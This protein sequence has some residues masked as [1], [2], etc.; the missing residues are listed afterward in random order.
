MSET[1]SNSSYVPPTAAA[2][3]LVEMRGIG[4]AFAGVRVL[5][6]VRFELR[7]GEVHVLAGENGA[8]KSTLMKIL[9]GVYA[10]YEGEIRL[11]GR[12]VRFKSPHH[13]FR[14]GIAVIHQEMSLIPDL[15]VVDNIFLGR[16][17]VRR[18]GWLDRTG[19]RAK[20]R[21]ILDQL[22]LDLDERRPAADFPVAI[23]QMIEIAKALT[24]AADIIIMDEPTATLNEPEVERLF[25][26]IAKL[27]AQS[28]GIVYISHKMEEIYRLG[29]R[30]TV[31]RDGR[32]INTALLSDLP[33]EEFIRW[34]VG[35]KLD[36]QF[37]SRRTSPGATRLD[38]T[39]FP[40]P[41]PAG[42]RK[43]AGAGVSFRVAAGEILGFAGLQGSGNSELFHGLFGA[44]GDPGG[45]RVTLD[46]QPFRS[47]S[48]AHSL[49][50]GMAL[51]T[52]DRKGN[53]LVPALSTT[54]NITLAA[55]KKFSP[56]G[57]LQPRAELTAA[58][59][60]RDALNIRVASLDQ[61]VGELSGG[62]Q[63]KVVLAKWLETA[64]KVLLL[65]EPTRGVDIGAKHEIYE[66]MNR[67]T[68]TGIS[69]L[70]ITSEMPELLALADRILVLHRGR[71]VAEFDRA[72]ATPEK[73]TQAAMGVMNAGVD[74]IDRIEGI[75]GIE[76]IESVESLD[77]ID[78]VDSHC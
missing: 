7:P 63:Q 16:E 48:P 52:N 44:C 27:K 11:D 38:V 58:T 57:W 25:A 70:L 72:A 78:S 10:E 17:P 39:D 29:D 1:A 33:Q 50:Q 71:I 65:D 6:D 75:E 76:R 40:L 42:R 55:L 41:D 12:L 64:P 56:Q 24:F 3:L 31:L 77:S 4:K 46:G 15:S 21:E 54:R 36:Q 73:I 9:C 43:A 8:G 20:A 34:L 22:G 49:R 26:L 19:Q 32:F 61:E 67:L 60:Q 45:G 30:A 28:K 74:R 5:E 62:N 66:L 69:I 37:P 35:R 18:G 68:A 2:P 23:R 53:G 51:L 13:A 59:A 47:V 14:H